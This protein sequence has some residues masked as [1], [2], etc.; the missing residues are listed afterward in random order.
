M[1]KLLQYNQIFEVL[2]SGTNKYHVFL[3]SR[4]SSS[5]MASTEMLE[6]EKLALTPVFRTSSA[7][8]AGSITSSVFLKI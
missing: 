1:G 2:F 5:N 4:G 8:T 7:P 6:R 3:P